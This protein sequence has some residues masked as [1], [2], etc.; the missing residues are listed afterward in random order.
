M[1]KLY[2]DWLKSMQIL[3]SR[4]HAGPGRAGTNFLPLTILL[5]N[6]CI[7]SQLFVP[8]SLIYFKEKIGSFVLLQ[9]T[10]KTNHLM[11]LY[12]NLSFVVFY[13][14][15]PRKHLWLW[16]CELWSTYGNI[17]FKMPLQR[18]WG[19]YW[20]ILVQWWL[21]MGQQW[22]HRERWPIQYGNDWEATISW[23]YL[24]K[25]WVWTGRVRRNQIH[26]ITLLEEHTTTERLF[27]IAK[28]PQI[29]RI[30]QNF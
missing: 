7:S 24:I 11:S 15:M 5:A 9:S 4:T 16:N 25:S 14:Y 27:S 30:C 13:R 22:M 17:M 29:D 12:K 6:L 23:H 28:L 19:Q 20:E 26:I 8:N 1:A 3:L 21:S 18:Q 2:R 10:D